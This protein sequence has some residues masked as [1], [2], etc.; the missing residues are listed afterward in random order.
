[1]AATPDPYTTLGVLRTASLLEIARA[2][3]RLAK[4]FHPD[5]AAAPEGLARMRAVN[6]A[7][8][9]L[10]NPATRVEWD[11]AH[12]AAAESPWPKPRTVD[13]WVEWPRARAT[14]AAAVANPG[15]AS[16][17]I[18]LGMVTLLL[19]GLIA[20]G[21]LS[22]MSRPATNGAD[23]PGYHDNLSP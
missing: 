6:A 11:R 20:M 16:G 5:V 2:R 4:R 17:W 3:R 23:S 1:V 14:P 21:V 9:L 8:E 18:V 22:T 12:A 13:S 19:V 15:G 10:S 7:W